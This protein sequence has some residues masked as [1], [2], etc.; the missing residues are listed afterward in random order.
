MAVSSNYLNGRLQ[1]R[2]I[3]G[4]DEKGNHLYRT[5]SYSNLKPAASD[6]DAYDVGAALAGLQEHGLEEVRRVS[7]AVLIDEP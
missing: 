4:M 1:L 6:Q 5:Q 2:L 7:E 3:V